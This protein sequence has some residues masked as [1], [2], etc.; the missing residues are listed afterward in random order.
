MSP[1]GLEVPVAGEVGSSAGTEAPRAFVSVVGD[2]AGCAPACRS[3]RERGRGVPG[4]AR[5]GRLRRFAQK[6][7][8]FFPPQKRP[9]EEQQLGVTGGPWFPGGELG[10]RAPRGANVGGAGPFSE[11]QLEAWA[12]HSETQALSAHRRLDPEPPLFLGT[13]PGP[14]PLTGT[15][16][17]EKQTPLPP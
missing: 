11:E 12:P 16:L 9:E 1:V 4:T 7:G 6:T 10:S 5:C 15:H 14:A 17:R 2:W 13:Q 3:P 8:A